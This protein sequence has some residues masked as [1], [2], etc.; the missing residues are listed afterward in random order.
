MPHCLCAGHVL[1]VIPEGQAVAAAVHPRL[2]VCY[3]RRRSL[4][5]PSQRAEIELSRFEHRLNLH[6]VMPAKEEGERR[7]CPH[8][9]RTTPPTPS[10]ISRDRKS[11]R[12]NSSHVA[13]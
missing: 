8:A 11:T 12:L 10:V 1:G 13:I 4:G 9:L 3:R 5:C 7:P 2:G 6:R